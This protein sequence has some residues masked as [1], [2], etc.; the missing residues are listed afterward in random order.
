MWESLS[1]PNK[2]LLIIGASFLVAIIFF[3]IVFIFFV[4]ILNLDFMSQRHVLS[5]I[6]LIVGLVIS[7]LSSL[8]I[9]KKVFT[10]LKKTIQ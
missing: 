3:Q 2:K 10:L 4:V 6:I 8:S 1:E 5:I 7:L 9:F